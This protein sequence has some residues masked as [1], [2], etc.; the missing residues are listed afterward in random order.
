VTN[1]SNTKNPEETNLQ[2][3]PAITKLQ[4]S[5]THKLLKTTGI[6][7]QEVGTVIKA[8][9]FSKLTTKLN[10]MGCAIS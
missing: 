7:D 4:A 8:S 10:G 5:S 2:K 6:S 3:R 9:Q 1:N